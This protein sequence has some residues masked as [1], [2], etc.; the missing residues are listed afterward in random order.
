[1]IKIPYVVLKSLAV[2]QPLGRLT[3]TL[4][5]IRLEYKFKQIDE[6]MSE[7]KSLDYI[8]VI[9]AGGEGNYSAVGEPTHCPINL[10]SHQ[11]PAS[12]MC[13]G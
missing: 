2:E 9:N 4:V 1:M 5:Y 3:C 13:P 6:D 8:C 12:Q 7:K 10:Q 11:V